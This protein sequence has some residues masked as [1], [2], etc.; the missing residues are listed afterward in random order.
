[1]LLHSRDLELVIGDDGGSSDYMIRV[2]KCKE[3]EEYDTDRAH[4]V[5]YGRGKGMF[6]KFEI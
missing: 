2:D 6:G 3:N 4:T 5:L 1:M